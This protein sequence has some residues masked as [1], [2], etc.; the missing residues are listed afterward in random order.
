MHRKA[1]QFN[2]VGKKHSEVAQAP[3][4][5]QLEDKKESMMDRLLRKAREEKEAIEREMARRQREIDEENR[6][7]A[8]LKAGHL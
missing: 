5:E 1:H 7:L 4:Q 2:F 6:K 3:P 8:A